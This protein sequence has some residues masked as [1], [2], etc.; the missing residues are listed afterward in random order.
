[1]S[2]WFPEGNFSI[3]EENLAEK[4]GK[5]ERRLYGSIEG[6]SIETKLR[7][8]IFSLEIGIFDDVKSWW[9]QRYVGLRINSY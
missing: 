3:Q 5:I 8:V 6:I 2:W 1:K 7:K 9:Q 4:Y